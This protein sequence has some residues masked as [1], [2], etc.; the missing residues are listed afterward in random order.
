MRYRSTI[1]YIFLIVL[2]NYG[3]SYA[4]YITIFGAPFSSADFAIG[5]I[6]VFRDLAQRELKH[7]VFVA[8][9]LGCLISYF[10]A[11]KSVAIASISAFSVGELIDWSIYTF[12]K[13]PLSKRLLWSASISAPID[14]G[15]FLYMINALNNAGF[16]VMIAGK[17][18]GVL[19]VWYLWRRRQVS[20]TVLVNPA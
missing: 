1:A 8:M 4:P 2:V 10:L 20:N 15:I 5:I 6:Y 11:N 12:T 14:T 16:F 19:F 3:I 13:R 17:I 9:F 18:T 7:Y